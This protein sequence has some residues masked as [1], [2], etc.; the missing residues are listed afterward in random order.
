MSTRFAEAYAALRRPFPKEQIGKLPSTSKRPALDY[1]G[2]AAVTDRLNT[3]V[4]E[5][6]FYT[7]DELL[8]V[9]SDVWIRGTF[10]L[11]GI[12]RV[13]YGDGKDPKEALGNFIRRGAMRF[14]VAIDLWSREELR[15]ESSRVGS[16]PPG[17]VSD[18]TPALDPGEST[19]APRSSERARP[20]AATAE[21]PRRKSRT[22]EPASPGS[23]AA[24]VGTAAAAAPVP[25]DYGEGSDGAG[26][27]PNLDEMAFDDLLVRAVEVVGKLSNVVSIVRREIDASVKTERDL[28]HGHL[29]A[30]IE[31][32]GAA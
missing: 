19:D 3:V 13:E 23:S 30:V 17:A 1:V 4:P 25:D 5:D 10:T 29:V 7:V 8:T 32:K 2:H 11:C 27:A 15:Y 18:G 12:S 14:G 16:S 24:P 9:G 6:W 31:R 22:H 28:E 21:A 20:G 26:A